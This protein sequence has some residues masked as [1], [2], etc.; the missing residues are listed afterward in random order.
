MAAAQAE[1][2]AMRKKLADLEAL[3][4]AKASEAAPPPVAPVTPVSPETSQMQDML[5][6]MND[7]YTKMLQLQAKQMGLGKP[8]EKETKT[9]HPEHDSESNESESESEEEQEESITTPDGKVVPWL[10]R[11][12]TGFVC[13][14]TS[15]IHLDFL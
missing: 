4:K 7:T 6:K 13:I 11:T 9:N 8:A 5:A 14:P 10:N 2:Q 1:Q 12:Y 15:F 3:V